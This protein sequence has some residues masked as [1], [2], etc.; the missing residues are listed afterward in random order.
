MPAENIITLDYK[1]FTMGGKLLG[2]GVM[3]TTSPDYALGRKE[4]LL[5][6]MKAI[7][8]KE[9]LDHILFSVVDIIKEQNT[10]FVIDEADAALVSDV[11]KV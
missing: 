6:A 9:Q 8:E 11:F 10:C 3:E 2:I 7:K 1:H 4:E 5:A